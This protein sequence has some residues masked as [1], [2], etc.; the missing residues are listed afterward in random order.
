MLLPLK[1]QWLVQKMGHDSL[2]TKVTPT[3]FDYHSSVLSRK[4]STG[5]LDF[6]LSR[7][8]R[9]CNATWMKTSSVPAHSLFFR[10]LLPG[11]SEEQ[12]VEGL[13]F[14]LLLLSLLSLLRM[15]AE[16]YGNTCITMFLIFRI[17][18]IWVTYLTHIPH[19]LTLTYSLCMTGSTCLQASSPQNYWMTQGRCHTSKLQIFSITSLAS[20]HGYRHRLFR[21]PTFHI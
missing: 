2:I 12:E 13:H 3:L 11:G 8:S 9:K 4:I 1:R 6:I 14:I 20:S 5:H 17:L 16:S 18:K 7:K 10:Y 19:A 21:K 15:V